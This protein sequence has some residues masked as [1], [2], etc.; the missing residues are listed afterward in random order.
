MTLA[1]FAAIAGVATAIVALGGVVRLTILGRREPPLGGG[2][3]L[4][5]RL[6]RALGV[7]IDAGAR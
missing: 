1:R 3:T 4:A 5:K 7:K 6:S 2:L